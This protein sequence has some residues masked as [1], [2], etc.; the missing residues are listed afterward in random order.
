MAKAKANFL[1]EVKEQYEDYPYPPR[2]PAEEKRMIKAPF[3]DIAERVNHYCFG[4]KRDF[5]KPYRILVAGGGTG[6]SSVFMAEQYGTLGAEIVHL[7]LSKA[8]IGVAKERLKMRGLENKVTFLHASLLDIPKMDL[9]KFDYINCS[10]V[11]HHLA[12]P[13]EGLAALESALAP[14]G[15]MGIMLYGK[16]GRLAIYPMQ[17]TLRIATQ[18]VTNRAEKVKTA[19]NI[20]SNLPRENWFL[21]SQPQF[22]WDLDS[23]NGLY[24]L[25]L[26]PQ[27]RAYSVPELHEYMASAG[28]QILSFQDDSTSGA[29]LYNPKRIVMSEQAQKE[30]DKL[31]IKD[32]QALAE[33]LAGNINKHTFYAGRKPATLPDPNDEDF[34]PSVNYLFSVNMKSLLKMVLIA[35]DK[36][37]MCTNQK[38]NHDIIVEVTPSAG[39]LIIAM[40]GKRTIR[41]IIDQVS[42]ATNLPRDEVKSHFLKLYYD[43]TAH[44]IIFLRHSSVPQYDN[45]DQIQ[46]NTLQRTAKK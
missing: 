16:Y 43:L 33:L 31:D 11:L 20:L 46:M 38:G 35:Q 29:H 12:S 28:L 4:G 19:R 6:D 27:D 3:I 21:F 44:D 22:Q 13:E 8:S 41:Q 14:D 45:L 37:I 26:H 24:D 15:I 7:D 10:G 30:I 1:Q 39:A 36:Y 40:D 17:E 32:Q 18:H 23:D 34:I 5:R 2:D 42:A 25:L 9:G